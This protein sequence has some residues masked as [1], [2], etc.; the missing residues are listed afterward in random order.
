MTRVQAVQIKL[1]S[2]RIGLFWGPV[3]VEPQDTGEVVDVTF[4]PP[5]MV[6]G[7]EFKPVPA[8]PES[9]QVGKT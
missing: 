7:V 3:L 9:P 2:G 5:R 4:E 1:K 6:S 8:A